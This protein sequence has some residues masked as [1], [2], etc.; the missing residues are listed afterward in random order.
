[1][2]KGVFCNISYNKKIKYDGDKVHTL[3]K[4]QRTK[5]SIY[6]NYNIKHEKGCKNS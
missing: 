6:Y 2:P 4:K 1:M 5:L 3:G